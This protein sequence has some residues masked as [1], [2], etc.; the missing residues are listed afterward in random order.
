L[1]KFYKDKDLIDFLL[2]N[3]SKAKEY[4]TIRLQVASTYHETISKDSHLTHIYTIDAPE[5]H[6]V[7]A[8]DLPHTFHILSR[9]DVAKWHDD[10]RTLFELAHGNIRSKI[11]RIEAKKRNWNGVTIF[12][13]FDRDYSASYCIDFGTNCENLVGQLGSIVCFPTKGSVFVHPVSDIQQFNIAFPLLVEKVNKFYQEDPGPITRNIYWY[14]G[15][16]SIKFGTVFEWE[17]L[18]Y[19]IPKKLVEMLG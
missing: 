17:E 18:T 6:T 2:N 4:L 14:F 13:L 12:T 8:L 5:T 9:K 11:D 19:T 3:Y 10:E 15:D 7:L 1:D 16:A